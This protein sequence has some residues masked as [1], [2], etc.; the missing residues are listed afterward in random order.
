MKTQIN[1][2]ISCAHWL[3]EPTLL[4]C[5]Y[6]RKQSTDSVKSKHQW[7]FF[8]ERTNNSKICMKTHTHRK[9]PNSQSYLEKGGQSWRYQA[10]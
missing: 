9:T 5:Q 1:K 6:Y 10:V 4:K 7:H 8:T 3:E 2:K